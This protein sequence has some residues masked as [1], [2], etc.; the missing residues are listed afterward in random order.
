MDWEIKYLIVQF[1]CPW[2]NSH[3]FT[4]N[5]SLSIYYKVDYSNLI[6]DMFVSIDIRFLD[7]LEYKEPK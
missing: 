4:M 3:Y 7:S 6:C 1:I 5:N 2:L